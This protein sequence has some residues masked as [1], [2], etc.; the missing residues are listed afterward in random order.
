MKE[1]ESGIPETK[2][3]DSFFDAEVVLTQTGSLDDVHGVGDLG[4]GHGTFAILA[5]NHIQ[6]T[7]YGFDIEPEMIAECERRAR[8]SNVQNAKSSLRDFMG[9]AGLIRDRWTL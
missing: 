4:C 3:W 7:L 1:R 2:T 9:E 6:G 5:A 8:Q